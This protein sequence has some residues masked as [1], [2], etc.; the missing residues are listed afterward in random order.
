MSISYFVLFL[1]VSIILQFVR[2]CFGTP[3]YFS[4]TYVHCGI[5]LVK[6]KKL[7][8]RNICIQQQHGEFFNMKVLTRPALLQSCL[9]E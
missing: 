7:T 5:E 2:E 9:F 1:T 4:S 8:V 3:S 6:V